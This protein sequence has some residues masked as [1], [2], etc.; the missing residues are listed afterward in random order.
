MSPGTSRDL[1]WPDPG[2]HLERSRQRAL[3]NLMNK[4][5][6]VMILYPCPLG[7]LREAPGGL[8]F[9]TTS[10]NAMKKGE[11]VRKRPGALLRTNA[12]IGTFMIKEKYFGRARSIHLAPISLAAFDLAFDPDAKAGQ[13]NASPLRAQRHGNSRGNET[14]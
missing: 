13:V 14:G 8:P 7:Q 10:E 3:Q 12:S 5:L 9:C 2:L 4:D 6:P 11:G 1:Q